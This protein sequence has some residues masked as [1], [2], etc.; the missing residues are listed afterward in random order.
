MFSRVNER[1]RVLAK[2]QGNAKAAKKNV[3]QGWPEL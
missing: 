3:L 1:L 2:K